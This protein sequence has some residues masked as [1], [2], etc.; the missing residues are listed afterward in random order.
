MAPVEITNGTF[1]AE[2]PNY[3]VDSANN[4]LMTTL[5]G[6]VDPDVTIAL[7]A[8]ISSYFNLESYEEYALILL[9]CLLSGLSDSKLVVGSIAWAI[10]QYQLVCRLTSVVSET[11][12]NYHSFKFNHSAN[13]PLA[14]S[15]L[16][17]SMIVIAVYFAELIEN[18]C[19]APYG[20]RWQYFRDNL[21]V[22]VIL[23]SSQEIW[24]YTLILWPL[25][26]YFAVGAL[27][28][29]E[30]LLIPTCDDI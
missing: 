12:W 7:L 5:P 2:L 25:P 1:M 24:R 29:T 17:L 8:A 4:T 22:K 18:V 15:I 11:Q 20:R 19:L 28:L 6:Y 30:D 14:L 13:V 16:P 10:V 3:I 26:P 21:H 9:D 23:R 27:P